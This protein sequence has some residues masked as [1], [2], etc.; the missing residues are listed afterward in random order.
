MKNIIQNAELNKISFKLIILTTILFSVL[1]LD[2]FFNFHYN[3]YVYIFFIEIILLIY[4]FRFRSIITIILLFSSLWSI[5][6]IITDNLNW[7]LSIGIVTSQLKKFFMLLC[8][9]F[10]PLFFLLKPK[11]NKLSTN[12]KGTHFSFNL[13]LIIVSVITLFKING[14]VVLGG[15]NGGFEGYTDNLEKGSG[16]IE[17]VLILFCYLFLF[18]KVNRFQN[19]ARTLIVLIYIVKCNLYGFRIQGI[20]ASVLLF[21]IFFSDRISALKSALIFFPSV[22]LAMLLGLAKHTDQ[23]NFALLLNNDAIESTHMGTTISGTIALNSYPTSYVASALSIVTWVV[24][25][26]FL[27]EKFPELYP[28][29]YAQD[30]L[31]AAGGMPFPVTGYL[32][33]K[34]FGLVVFSIIFC[35]FFYV[36]LNSNKSN[37]FQ[38]LSMVIIV[39]FPRWILYDF[40]NFGI[41]TLVYSFLF[42]VIINTIDKKIFKSKIANNY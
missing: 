18:K 7:G 10:L 42:F 32:F 29:K 9:G 17:Y 8:L 30:K 11:E 38:F 20:M 34:F 14:V 16:I 25:P 12:Y 41:R 26:A 36:I 39:F 35:Y 19:Y 31:G 40:V 21:Y 37:L 4:K 5:E 24:P 28:S 33:A 2:L 13:I 22:L 27:A 15:S 1:I 6:F 3:T 23:L